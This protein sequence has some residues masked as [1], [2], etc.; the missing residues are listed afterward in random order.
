MKELARGTA[1]VDW[2]SA[3]D[4]AELTTERTVRHEAHLDQLLARIRYEIP[5]V[6]SMDLYFDNDHVEHVSSGPYDS[7]GR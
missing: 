5:S 3:A 6:E 4:V 2:Y 7:S 1:D